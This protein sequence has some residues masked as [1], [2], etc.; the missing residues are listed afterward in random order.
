MNY[1]NEMESFIEQHKSAMCFLLGINQND[2]LNSDLVII[3]SYLTSRAG[4]SHYLKNGKIDPCFL[5]DIK[6]IPIEERSELILIKAAE[7]HERGGLLGKKVTTALKKEMIFSPKLELALSELRKQKCKESFLR[8]SDSMSDL[9][10][11]MKS[12][13]VLLK[14]QGSFNDASFKFQVRQTIKLIKSDLQK[15][16]Y[17]SRAGMIWAIK[18]G[19]SPE[20]AS[21]AVSQ[22]YL[23]YLEPLSKSFIAVDQ[24]LNSQGMKSNMSNSIDNMKER[25]YQEVNETIILHKQQYK[26]KINDTSREYRKSE[27][28]EYSH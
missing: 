2:F 23:R 5:D 27:C 21:S 25:W 13:T 14:G 3:A 12:L 7:W 22:V 16:N 24:L 20:K 11:H 18:T 4:E 28:L 6:K 17:Q 8:L 9:K 10:K 15:C 19:V 1:K 26:E